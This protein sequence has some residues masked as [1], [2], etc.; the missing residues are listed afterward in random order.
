MK[1]EK[2]LA[3][4]LA[5]TLIGLL[6]SLGMYLI[7]ESGTSFRITK[8]MERS[9]QAFNMAEA[10]LQLGL[11][12]IRNSPPSPSFTQLQSTTTVEIP[13]GYPSFMKSQS[14]GGGTITPYVDYVGY[15]TTPPP[16]WMLNWQ[17]YSSFYGLYFQSRGQSQISLPGS[18]GSSQ[19]RIV[20]FALKVTR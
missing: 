18:Q 20:S 11:R 17:G 13:V 6:S 5:I 7:V 9:E 3:M 4:V 2:G 12:C 10:A 15:R 1:N 8:A 16:G 19:S 14:F